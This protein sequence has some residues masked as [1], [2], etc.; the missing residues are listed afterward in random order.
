[1]LSS[2]LSLGFSLTIAKS[3]GSFHSFQATLIA[4]QPFLRYV[5]QTNATKKVLRKCTY[6]EVVVTN[7]GL[8]QCRK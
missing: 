3:K 4:L 5:L 8:N 6:T 2:K 7:Q 1:M